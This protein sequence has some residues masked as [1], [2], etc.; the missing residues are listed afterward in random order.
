VGGAEFAR[1]LEK[2]TKRLPALQKCGPK[3]MAHREDHQ[4]FAVCRSVSLILLK[5]QMKTQ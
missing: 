3:K 5:E 2:E 4:N 1:A